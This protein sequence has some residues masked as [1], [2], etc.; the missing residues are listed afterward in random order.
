MVEK[1]MNEILQVLK[2]H[3]VVNIDDYTPFPEPH[4][5][6]GEIKAILLGMDPS[7]KDKI[8]FNTVFNLSGKD[9]RYFSSIQR[10]LDSIGLSTNNLYVQNFCQN[11]FNKTTYEQQNNWWRASAIWYYFLKKELDSKFSI[12]IPLLATSEMIFHRLMYSYKSNS[13]YY[14]HPEILPV[15]SSAIT[16]GRMVFPFYRHWKYNLNRPEWEQYKKRLIEY[17]Q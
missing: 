2:R 11:Y 16:S 12:D 14:Q 4:H 1:K 17:F 5:G 6:K 15:E 10:N 7:T 8:R 13:Y 9:K 3:L